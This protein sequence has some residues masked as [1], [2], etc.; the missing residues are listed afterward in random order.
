[1]SD[2]DGN[3]SLINNRLKFRDSPFVIT[4]RQ[5]SWDDP[6]AVKCQLLVSYGN[7]SKV[8]SQDI[9]TFSM[10]Q[11]ELDQMLGKFGDLLQDVFLQQTSEKATQAQQMIYGGA[12]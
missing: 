6:S 9:L 12:A 1:M 8:A 7:S 3:T 10:S 11:T 4:L 2:L 5:A